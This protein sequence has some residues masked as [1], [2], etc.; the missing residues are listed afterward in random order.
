MFCFGTARNPD[1]NSCDCPILKNLGLRIKKHTAADN[2]D[3]EAASRA[4]AAVSPAS[5]ATQPP[6]NHPPPD[7]PAG[8]ASA[9]GTFSASTEHVSYDSGD[10]FDYEGKAD[11]AMYGCRGKSNASS[12]YLSPSCRAVVLDP[13][14]IAAVPVPSHSMGGPPWFMGGPV[15]VVPVP[16]HPMGDLS[17]SMGG[18]TASRGSVRSPQGMGHPTHHVIHKGLTPSTF[19]RQSLHCF[20]TL[21]GTCSFISNKPRVA[22]ARHSWW[23]IL[24]QPTIYYQTRPRSFPTTQYQDVAFR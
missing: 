5:G 10:E 18:P 21:P 4:V 12:A 14:S 23:L 3:R 20:K 24:E 2:S 7:N 6:T 22:P 16:S 8:A 17:Q 13:P 1:H 19:P 11:G 9:P 15:G